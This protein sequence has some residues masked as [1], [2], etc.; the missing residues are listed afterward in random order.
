MI[1]RAT[2]PD[3]KLHKRHN[4]LSFHFVSNTLAAKFINLQQIG[5][6]FNISDIISKHWSY[7]S[8]YANLLQPTF[9]FEGDTGHLFDD[10]TLTVNCYYE[11]DVSN[12]ITVQLMGNEKSIKV[13]TK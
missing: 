10:D 6:E 13:S 4:I 9:Y 1:K 7:Q 12:C 3:A 2:L 5:S 8:V 11:F